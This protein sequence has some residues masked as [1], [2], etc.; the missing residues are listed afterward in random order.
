MRSRVWGGTAAVV[1]GGLL[2]AGCG[3]EKDTGGAGKSAGKPGSSVSR[4]TCR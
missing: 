1:L 3:G 2:A 4:L